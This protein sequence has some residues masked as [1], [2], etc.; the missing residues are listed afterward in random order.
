MSKKRTILEP[1][2]TYNVDENESEDA[3]AIIQEGRL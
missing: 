3:T 2:L 1:E